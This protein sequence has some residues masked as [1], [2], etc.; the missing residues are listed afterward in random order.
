MASK[1]LAHNLHPNAV[2]VIS[3]DHVMP[4]DNKT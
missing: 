1:E 4:V 2:S 3:G